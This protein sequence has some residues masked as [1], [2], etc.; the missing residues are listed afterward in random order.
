MTPFTKRQ[1]RVVGGAAVAAAAS[2]FILKK[3]GPCIIQNVFGR[4]KVGKSSSRELVQFQ[5][6]KTITAKQRT[7]GVDLE[8][9]DQVLNL[10]KIVFPG[11]W[12]KQVGFLLLHSGCLV[13]R[14]FLSIYV[15]TLDGRIV[16]S[17]VQK[18]V[19]KFI[20][21]LLE[22]IGLA[23]PATF[24]NSM[25]R[26]LESK[27]ALA[28]RTE[29]VNYA[30]ERYFS[31]QT[32]YR[33][34]NLDGRLVNADECLTEDIRMFCS[35]VAHLYS[36]LTKPC[37]DVLVIC[38]TLDSIARRRGA[39]WKLP[40]LIAAVVIYFTAIILRRLSPK[41]GSLVAEESQ[42]RGQLRFLHSR[43]I[44]NAEEI[45]FYGGHKVRNMYFF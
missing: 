29:L 43:V 5:P 37:L 25:I 38:W 17:V 15:A 16:K 22:W 36:H 40:L 23:I 31:N 33:V 12:T 27:I 39:S 42:R 26:Y 28:F 13:L 19:P 44:T 3:Y 4:R 6:Q 30:Y 35:S 21:Q 45:A 41:F 10:L 9:L 11:L 18:N 2:A 7:T 8:F 1:V 32:Y 34:G 14:T 24:V 20:L